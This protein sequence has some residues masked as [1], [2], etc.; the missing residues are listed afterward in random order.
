MACSTW[1]S[2]RANNLVK[3]SAR[4]GIS[5]GPALPPVPEVSWG[6]PGAGKSGWKRIPPSRL[7]LMANPA[8]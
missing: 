3:E 5:S 7:S 4:S 8:V 2:V 6:L 1:W